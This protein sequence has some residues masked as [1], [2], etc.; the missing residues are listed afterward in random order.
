MR[1]REEMTPMSHSGGSSETTA[2][3][4]VREDVRRLIL[5]GE[6]R[7][8]TR[9]TQQQLAKRF[10]V[11]Q[12]VIRESLLELQFTGLVRSVDNLGVFV[13]DLDVEQLLQGYEVREALEGLAA[14]LCC[15]RA[16]R[17]DVREL[18][19]IVERIYELG[20]A[21]D[22]V[23]RGAL[24]REFHHR[25]ILISQNSILGRLTEVHHVLGLIVLASRAHDVICA[26][27]MAIVKAI[28]ANDPDEAEQAARRHVAGVRRGI[29][30]HQ[31]TGFQF[32]PKWIGES[33][34]PAPTSAE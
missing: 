19:E 9:L 17:A 2:R 7:S 13:G 11:A 5:S 26:E 14:R 1:E 27:H 28:E 8:G 12:S 16:S 18:G 22:D 33:P 32:V 21:G 3:G 34:P 30:E 23:E 20:M 31:G 6:L 29:R 24:D 4:R 25:I 10:G 15:E